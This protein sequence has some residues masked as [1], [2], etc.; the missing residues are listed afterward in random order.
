MFRWWSCNLPVQLLCRRT[1]TRLYKDWFNSITWHTWSGDHTSNRSFCP[2]RP[3]A[4]Y[5]KCRNS[6]IVIPPVTG[7]PWY[8]L[9]KWNNVQVWEVKGYK[10]CVPEK[11]IKPFRLGQTLY[12]TW[13]EPKYSLGRLITLP[14]LSQSWAGWVQLN[15]TGTLSNN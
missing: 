5:G 2:R 3:F 4:R 7:H 11:L 13:A 1:W 14:W 6:R 9:K 8:K 15:Q 10:H 12:F